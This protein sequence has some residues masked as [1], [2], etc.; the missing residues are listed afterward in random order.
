MYAKGLLIH[1]NGSHEFRTITSHLDIRDAVGGDFDWAPPGSVNFYCYEYALFERPLNPVATQL[2]HQVHP[3][4]REPL[5]GPVLVLGPVKGENETDV[6][7]A[8][9]AQVAALSV[10]FKPGRKP[11]SSS[12]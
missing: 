7:A 10:L 11:G 2:Y 4:I 1:H 12:R 5:N 9:V 8:V 6:P 3:H